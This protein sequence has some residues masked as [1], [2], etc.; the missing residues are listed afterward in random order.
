[1]TFDQVCYD[2]TII[3]D[4]NNIVMKLTYWHLIK[5]LIEKQRV[6]VRER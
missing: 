5:R 2:Y 1:M 4:G 6:Q 3:N